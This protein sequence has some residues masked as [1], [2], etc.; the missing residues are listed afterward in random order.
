MNEYIELYGGSYIF[1]LIILFFLFKRF[2]YSYLDPHILVIQLLAASLSFSIDSPFF[3]YVLFAA[4]SFYCGMISIS[5]KVKR[6]QE[7]GELI[8]VS[9]LKYYS[10]IF[11]II[12][13]FANIYLYKDT[14]IPLFADNPTEEKVASFSE[15]SGWLR[16]IIFVSSILPICFSLLILFSEK[17]KK[18][19]F[20]LFAYIGISV[21]MGAKSSFLHIVFVL[22]FLYT[23]NSFK[24]KSNA[25]FYTI[26]KRYTWLAFLLGFAI[27]T[28]I[29][30]KE[31]DTEGGNF[32]YSIGFRLM[33]AGDVML[34]YKFDWIRNSFNYNWGDF[35]PDEV[36]GITGMLRIA[37][38][39]D[40]IGYVMVKEYLGRELS[41]VLGPNAPFFIKGHIYF[42]YVGG[43]IYC[44]IIGLVY[45]WYRKKIFMMRPRN[46]FLYTFSLN[47]FFLLINFLK[48][49][50]MFIS[51][52]FD[53]CIISIPIILISNIII[54]KI[55]FKC[56]GKE[57]KQV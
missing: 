14:Q 44:F 10:I 57:S 21:L 18:Y 13:V 28:F 55:N 53:L 45:A 29:V 12:Y 48:E 39:K 30:L 36:N 4:F 51:R 56:N 27:F 35:I 16:R 31:A 33:A 3:L 1:F 54:N 5:T 20:M 9:L 11:F 19:I 24:N 6:C 43:I 41:T 25:M 42:G 50:G 49:S 46:I 17:K 2:L 52:L 26:V 22:S 23:Q 32:F 7:V 38:Y 47:I 15:G 34:Y 8:D 40:P 37:Q